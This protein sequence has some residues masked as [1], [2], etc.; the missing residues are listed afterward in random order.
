MTVDRALLL[1]LAMM[2]SRSFAATLTVT[3]VSD[4]GPGTLRAAIQTANSNGTPD[5]ITFAPALKGKTI[6]PA[7]ELPHLTEASTTIDGDLDN[8]GVPDIA[9]DGVRLGG[10]YWNGLSV[11]ANDTIIEGLSIVRFGA[12]GVWI[13][14][15]T[16]CRVQACY[17]GV[18]RNGRT[19]RPNTFHQVSLV[20]ADGSRVGAPGKRNVIAVPPTPG[21]AAI[22]L[23]TTKGAV[24][25]PNYIGTNAAGTAVLGA[26]SWAI[27]VSLAGNTPG[28]ADLQGNVIRDT[29]F[30]GMRKGVQMYNC[31]NNQVRGCTFGLAANGS[32]SLPMR[33][34]GDS[35]GVLLDHGSLNNVIGGPTAGCRNTFACGPEGVGVYLAGPDTQGNRVEGNY[36]GTNAAG[37]Q[38]RNLLIGVQLGTNAGAQ[39]IGGS[40]ASRGN[41]FAMRPTPDYE[42]G[43]A[44]GTYGNGTVVR[45]NCF[46]VLPASGTYVVSSDLGVRFSEVSGQAL[47]N[48]FAR[49]DRAVAAGGASA[50][51]SVFRN[52]FRRCSIGV[53]ILNGAR[54]K[55]GNLH[56]ASTQDDGGNVFRSTGLYHISNNTSN[57]IGAEGNDFGSKK[58]SVIDA[59]IYDKLDNASYGRV[60]FDPLIGGVHPSG[61]TQGVVALTGTCA[62][63]TPVGA[64]IAYTLS[65]PATVTVTIRNLA[66]RPVATVIRDQAAAA[67]LQRTLWSGCAENGLRVPAGAYVVEVAARSADGGQARVLTTLRLP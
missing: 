65:S 48:T 52:T 62:M 9:L 38:Q 67:G 26:D 51:P 35:Y 13:N 42:I 19:S 15:A 4:S 25:G 39:T 44:F 47:D 60:D 6:A 50:T 56:N 54:P 59:K 34:S 55:L 8:D 57:G 2:P 49:L 11:T 22:A 33:A 5:R 23:V 16:N 10:E 32:K 17:L 64:E 45:N 43:V 27:G 58:Q 1:T 20:G 7:T 29:V 41:Y 28:D 24:V 18:A 14:Y 46:G 63:P 3:K 30:A 53:E 36:F 61:D 66:G 21:D 40:T 31:S 37:T 12:A